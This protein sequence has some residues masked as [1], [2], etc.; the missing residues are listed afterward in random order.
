M[1]GDANSAIVVGYELT[2]WPTTKGEE[3]YICFS[4]ADKI[5]AAEK[6]DGKVE[7]LGGFKFTTYCAGS[8]MIKAT[9]TAL[10]GVI[11]ASAF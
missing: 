10:A 1:S 7:G 6:N 11:A 2:E 4:K 9:V 3:K 5:L 8:T